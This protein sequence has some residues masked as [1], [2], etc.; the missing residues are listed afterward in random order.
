MHW[1]GPRAIHVGYYSHWILQTSMAY[2]SFS[3]VVL[4][5]LTNQADTNRFL[6]ALDMRT[7]HC[8][9]D[10]A[11][12]IHLDLGAKHSVGVHWGT[13]I[14]SDEHYL[15][16]PKDLAIARKKYGV[17]E[18]NFCTIPPGQTLIFN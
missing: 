16:P 7:Q 15:D 4:S 5:S 3:V 12:Q 8:D 2:V 1:S 17:P 11:V 14:L 10:D 18:E 13:W 6:N 9:P